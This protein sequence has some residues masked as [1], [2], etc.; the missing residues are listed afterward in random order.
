M[1][2]TQAQ[3]IIKDTFE[4]SFNKAN[5]QN[6]VKNLLNNVESAPF[7]YQGNYIPDAYKEYIISLERLYKYTDG[8]HEIDILVV[9]LKKQTSIE[10]ARTMQRNFIAWY[11][12]GSRKGKLK[13]AA[14]VAFVSPNSEDWRFSFVKMDYRF[15]ETPSG[16]IKVKEEFTPARRWSFLVGANE[17]SHTAQSR[18]IPLLMDDEHK[19]TLAQLEE[20]FNIETVTKEFFLKYRELFIRTKEALDEVVARNEKVK[21]DFDTKEIDTVNFAKKLLGQVVFLYFLQKKGWFGVDRDADWG[22]GPKDFLRRLFNR[23]YGPYHNF[24]NDILEPLFYEALR[25]DRSHDDHY[26]SRFNCKI[27]FLNGGLFDPIG[28]YDWVHTDITLPNELFSNDVTT[29]EGDIGNGILDIFDRYNFTVKEDE[30][31]EK[32]VAIDPELLGK[33]YE[34]FNAIRP[35]NF[36]E[37]KKALK[38]ASSN[39]ENKFNKTFGVYYTPREIVHYMC[40]QSLIHYLYT[41]VEKAGLTESIKK[42]DIEDLIEVGEMITE[43]EATA[44]IKEQ[45]IKN[46]SQKTSKYNSLLANSIKDHAATIDKWLADITVCDPAVGS[47]AFPV[48]MMHEIVCARNILSVFISE[49]NRNDY[50]F[51]RHCIEHSIYGVDIDPGAVEIAKLRLWLSLVVEEEDI[52]QIKPLP[53]LDYKIVCGNSLLGLEKNL[54]NDHLFAELE[55]LK[56]LYFNETNPTDKQKYKKQIDDLISQITNGHSEFDFEVYFSEVFHQKGGFDVVIGNPPYVSTKGVD[57]EFKKQLE[58]YFGFADDLYNHFYFKGME[59]LKQKGILAF[60]SSKTFWTIQT[61]KN[62][63]EF[64]LR[65]QLLSLFDTANP[66][67]SAMVDTSVILVMKNANAENYTFTYLDGTKDILNPSKT[68]GNIEYYRQAPNRVFYPITDYNLKIFEKYGKKVNELLNK[69]WDKISTSK[70]IEKYK[71]ELEQ[72]RNALKPGDITLLGLITEGGVGIQTGNNGKY[73]GVLE[74]TKW[75]ENVRKQRPEKLLLATE[76]CKKNN[77]TGKQEAQRY[78]ETLS[79]HEI[80][81]LFDDLKEKYGRDVFGQGWLYRIV[82]PDEIAD[83]EALTED[84]KL[85]GIKGNR[86]FVPYDKGDK[87]GNRWYAPTPYYIDWS[88][89]NV[90]FLKENSGKKGE[91]MPV[92]RNPQFYFR[93]G[94][95]WNNVL[96]DEKIKCRMKEKSVH[97]TEAMTFISLLENILPNYYLVCMLNSTFYGQYRMLFI[98]TSHHLTTGDAKEFPIIIPNETQLKAFES[99]FN[100]AVEIQ[101]QKFV[102][103]I[104]EPE[105]ELKLNEIQKELDEMVEGMYLK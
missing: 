15:E 21:A 96:S 25:V 34:K 90:K 99:I 72:Y 20:A 22:T 79:E 78:L 60:I 52:R 69:W 39:E 3:K 76:F 104:S 87:D 17:A 62:L 13:D 28:N 31:L 54:F 101:K 32:D 91:G 63:R 81:N 67:E 47:G 8:E 93:E 94:F 57:N 26:Y 58:K 11:L 74:R 53:N 38:N 7:T 18:F 86:T 30:P 51:K 66:F 84:E 1:D 9:Q 40:K 105:A 48:G 80:R 102:G 56:P 12:N 75:A 37:Y 73:I 27:P 49:Q 83:V 16:K 24:F 64:I 68:I 85:N 5:F 98:N 41:C 2:K 43:H 14:L 36:E 50:A 19:P 42:Q 4:N 55:K 10:R 103:K 46:G 65:N 70:N 89:E 59:I 45:K 82:S 95:C 33:V 23:E 97:S 61:K 100:R 44:N 71:R 6:F 88:R 35:D 77:I 92:V 29:K